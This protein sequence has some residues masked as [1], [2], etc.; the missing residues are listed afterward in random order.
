MMAN[1]GSKASWKSRTCVVCKKIIEPRDIKNGRQK[2]HLGKCQRARSNDRSLSWWNKKY[3]RTGKKIRT[4]V[5]CEKPMEPDEITS[6][7]Q[8]THPGVCK[9]K[10]AQATYKRQRDEYQTKPRYHKAAKELHFDKTNCTP[11]QV[12]ILNEALKLRNR[13]I[14]RKTEKALDKKT[15]TQDQILKIQK[16]WENL[17]MGPHRAWWWLIEDNPP[18]GFS[19]EE[20]ERTMVKLGS[21]EHTEGMRGYLDMCKERNITPYGHEKAGTWPIPHYKKF[22]APPLLEFLWIP[23]YDPKGRWQ[24]ALKMNPQGMRCNIP[25]D[26]MRDSFG[27]PPPTAWKTKTE[28]RERERNTVTYESQEEFEK[29]LMNEPEPES[30]FY[31]HDRQRGIINES[32]EYVELEHPPKDAGTYDRD[33]FIDMSRWLGGFQARSILIPQYIDRFGER[34][35][36]NP[37]FITYWF[38][39]HD[40]IFSGMYPKDMDRWMADLLSEFDL[41]DEDTDE[42]YVDAFRETL[43]SVLD[44]MSFKEA[45]KKT[46][47]RVYIE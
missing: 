33:W 16:S 32:D 25:D 37:Y 3:D 22:G 6:P 15:K 9:T 18:P 43:E 11:E 17:L 38:R 19:D 13:Y 35:F 12:T 30:D 8:K 27:D 44:G 10:L 26:W 45:F 36:E 29:D 21:M 46:A 2:T 42:K 4:C 5:V 28:R 7:N 34:W 20:W 47:Y 24:H 39:T 1:H 23:F 31:E 14:A 41:D 40:S